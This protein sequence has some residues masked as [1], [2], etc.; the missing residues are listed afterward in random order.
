MITWLPGKLSISFPHFKSASPLIPVYKTRQILMQHWIIIPR[1]PANSSI[2][3]DA[4]YRVFYRVLI[5]RICI[6]GA[7]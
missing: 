4:I 5:Y 3:R 2:R 1:N 6:F 7:I